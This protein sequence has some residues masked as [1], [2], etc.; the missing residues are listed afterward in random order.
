MSKWHGII[1]FGITEETKPG[2]CETRI[3]EK[4]YSGDLTRDTRKYVGSGGI[5][6]NLDISN[7]LS[8]LADPYAYEHFHTIRYV[9]IYAAR[10]KVSSVEI[11]RPRLIL[12]IGGVYNGPEARTT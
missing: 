3:V 9:N 1:G 7:M 12:S 10:W 5:N 6:D 8:V 11:Q 4:E 2:V